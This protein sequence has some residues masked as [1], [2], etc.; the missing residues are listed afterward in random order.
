MAPLEDGSLTVRVI[1]HLFPLSFAMP[2]L[3]GW[4]Y[5]GMLPSSFHTELMW[6]VSQTVVFGLLSV[7]GFW[8]LR[9]QL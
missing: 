9:R 2:P 8:H 6:L 4:L 5:F 1:S 7:F 3:S